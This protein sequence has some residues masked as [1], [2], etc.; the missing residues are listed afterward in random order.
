MN[1]QKDYSYGV[2]PVYK[3]DSGDFRFLIVK[4]KAGHWTFPKGHPD[5]DELCEETIKRELFEETGIVDYKL[6]PDV[7]FIIHYD[8]Q[9][10]GESV[11][12]EVQYYIGIM[13][14]D[15]VNVPDEFK[16]EIPDACWCTE[17]QVRE[18]CEF[19]NILDVL[20]DTILYLKEHN[21]LL[22]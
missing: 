15:F 3:A 14:T 2:V 11:E 20:D 21:S 1:P 4:H 16:D 17:D 6:I 8:I 13:P 5:V 9:L 12:K 22:D 18:R 19:Q 7:S 10:N